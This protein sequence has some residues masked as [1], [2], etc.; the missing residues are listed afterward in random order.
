MRIG[1]CIPKVT[2][3]HSE[4]VAHIVFPLQQ[5]S[6]ERGSILRYGYIVRLV[7]RYVT[8]V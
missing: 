3:T 4:C 6:Q 2:N 8:G 7:F 1:C 5:W